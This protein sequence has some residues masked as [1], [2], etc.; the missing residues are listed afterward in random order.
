MQRTKFRRILLVNWRADVT[1]S[2]L[3]ERGAIRS[4]LGDWYRANM[5]VPPISESPIGRFVFTG[6]V[7]VRRF[8][9]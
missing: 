8:N 2:A 4:C 6:E 1:A 7:A 5:I 9:S 3:P